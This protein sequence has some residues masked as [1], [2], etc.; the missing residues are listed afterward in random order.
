MPWAGFGNTPQTKPSY[1]ADRYVAYGYDGL[2]DDLMRG[3]AV[4]I[5]S[6]DATRTP[7]CDEVL[8]WRYTHP[9]QNTLTSGQVGAG[10]VDHA[11]PGGGTLRI[12]YPCT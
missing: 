12:Y 5:G 2:R 11:M 9:G 4:P 3:T 8:G 10:A 6:T 7:P 1:L